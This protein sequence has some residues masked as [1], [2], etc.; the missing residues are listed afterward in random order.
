MAH[1]VSLA[2]VNELKNR[3]VALSKRNKSIRESGKA[4]I[5]A[6][7]DSIVTNAGG[8]GAGIAQ[9][10]FGEKRFL[11]VWWE[12]YAAAILHGAGIFIKGDTSRQF[13]NLADG[14]S[15]A[16]SSAMG[17]GIGIRMLRQGGGKRPS[18]KGLEDKIAELEGTATEG[19]GMADDEEMYRLARRM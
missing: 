14:I 5:I 15:T 3:V 8:F 2:K 13:H 16:W 11:G 12:L 6:A 18:L 4:T 10:Y 7:A 19:G 9:G 1:S 17:R